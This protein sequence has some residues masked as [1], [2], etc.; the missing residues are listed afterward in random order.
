MKKIGKWWA[1]KSIEMIEIDGIVYALNGWN[2]ESYLNCWEC[3]GDYL[4]DSSEKTYT[5]VP[6]YKRC[7]NGDFILVTYNVIDN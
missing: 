7:K 5:L 3:T 4:M 2:G 6:I 1:D